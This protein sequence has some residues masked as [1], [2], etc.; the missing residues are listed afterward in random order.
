MEVDEI[1]SAYEELVSLLRSHA[2]LEPAEGWSAEM[3]G[4]HVAMNNHEIASVAERVAR[5]ETARYDNAEGVDD[6]TLRDFVTRVGGR[7]GV[8]DEVE[9][10]ARRMADAKRR[11][12]PEAALTEVPVIIHDNGRVVVDGPLPIGDFIVGNAT[13]HL[14][15]H[16]EQLRALN[17]E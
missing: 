11:L 8:A 1:E 14:E 3:I 5:G 10:S 13:F 4:A 15:L 9:R 16:T 12:T 2:S 7:G 6:A 17:D